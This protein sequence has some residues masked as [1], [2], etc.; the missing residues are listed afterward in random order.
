MRVGGGRRFDL[1][2][3]DLDGTLVAHDE[4]IWATLHR[5]LGSDPARRKSV[6]R[7]A[8]AGEISYPEWLAADVAMLRDAGATR[9]DIVRV[10]EN[11]AL[12]P[13]ALEVLDA[14]DAVGCRLAVLSGGLDLVAHRLLPEHLVVHV[15]ANRLEFDADGGLVGGVATPYD[16][17]GKA[18]G[19]AFL[20]DVHAVA[21]ERIAFVGNGMNDVSA[22][23]G[24]LLHRL[25]RRAAGAD[26]GR[27]GLRRRPRS[28]R[29]PAAPGRPRPHSGA[30]QLE[31][32]THTLPFGSGRAASSNANVCGSPSWSQAPIMA[33]KD[34]VATLAP[35][36]LQSVSVFAISSSLPKRTWVARPHGSPSRRVFGSASTRSPT[37]PA[38]SSRAAVDQ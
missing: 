6:L 37:A 12:T 23:R 18:D 15:S 19:L 17:H 9:A 30:R 27:V 16:R 33:L 7:A 13:G 1:V 28:A 25:E 34:S 11:L 22:R 20:A 8:L 36:A 14:L 38:P 32:V 10:I 26:R 31:P 35:P 3:F 29:H 5:R 2:V 21:R 24:G 4:P